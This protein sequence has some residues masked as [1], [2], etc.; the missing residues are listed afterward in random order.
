MKTKNETLLLIDRLSRIH[1]GCGFIDDQSVDIGFKIKEICDPKHILEIG[2]YAGHSSCVWLSTTEANV[3]SVDI[4][5][6]GLNVHT[7]KPTLE[8]FDKEFPG[9]HRFILGDSTSQ[10][11]FEQLQ[12]IN[13]I[14]QFDF[15]F[16]DG[17][18]HANDV[19]RD[20][21]SCLK[22]KIPYILFDDYNIHDNG[23]H[24]VV[25]GINKFMSEHPNTL[26][27]VKIFNYKEGEKDWRLHGCQGPMETWVTT[28]ALFKNKG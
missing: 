14:Q 23:S 5:N 22:L 16:I 20:I 13:N 24:Q 15:A 1:E 17:S 12:I 2:F 8:I 10:P 18:H 28:C 3:T 6:C 21:E 9:R 11:V 19:I 4:M 26:E 7:I 25:Y 27:L